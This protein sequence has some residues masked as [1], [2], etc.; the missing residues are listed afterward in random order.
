MTRTMTKHEWQIIA[1]YI[2]SILVVFLYTACSPDPPVIKIFNV[3]PS[4]I[5][6]GGSAILQWSVEGAT[7]ITI[8]QGIG[9]VPPTGTIIVSPSKTIAYTLTA[10]NAGSTVTRS[11]VLYV[12]P[13]TVPL[14]TDTIPPV[15]KDVTTSIQNETKAIISWST[16]EPTTG[17]VEY[18]KSTGYGDSIASKK[19]DT[20]HSVTIDGLDHNTVYHF[21]IVAQDEAGNESTSADNI[22]NT[23]P[24]KSTFSLELQQLEWGR[25]GEFEGQE[26]YSELPGR[27]FIYIKGSAQNISNA[28][29][30]TVICTMHCW[31]GNKLVKSEV[32]VHQAPILPGYVFNFEIKTLDDPSVDNVT[33]EFADHLGRQIVIK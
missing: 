6:A 1:G 23:P 17:K 12:N 26:G 5:T 27:K 3:T 21:R 9:K 11:V 33:I 24:P 32:Y 31:S 15:I 22:F 30:R 2:L 19:L 20:V 7:T 16:N 8:D 13:V 18:G 10:T 25:K 29:L 4:E 28:T 14:T